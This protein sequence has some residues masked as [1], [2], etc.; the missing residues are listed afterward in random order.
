MDIW[1][2]KH[3][4]L[5]LAPQ[6]PPKRPGIVH[7]CHPSSGAGDLGAEVDGSVCSCQSARVAKL[8][9]SRFNQ[10]TYFKK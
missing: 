6:Y 4:N 2:S 1:V 3:K 8:V 9:V 10:R 5:S 7:A